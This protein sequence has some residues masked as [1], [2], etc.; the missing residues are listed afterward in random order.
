MRFHAVLADRELV[1]DLAV[2]VALTDMGDDHPLALGQLRCSC[3][4]RHAPPRKCIPERVHPQPR[5]STGRRCPSGHFHE[6]AADRTIPFVE[7]P[8]KGVVAA[9]PWSVLVVESDDAVRATVVEGLRD[10]GILV[11]A[12]DGADRINGWRG[13]VIVTDTFTSPYN[14]ESVVAYLKDLRSRYA[15]GLVV[16]TGHNGA[17][18][19]AAQLPADAVVM[20]PFDLDELVRVVTAVARDRRQITA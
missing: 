11:E 6:P 7:R 5:M 3:V 13:D 1:A 12:T 16:L 14:T 4:N 15:A 17:S 10:S 18:V 19:A 9:D 2:A 20:K 8:L